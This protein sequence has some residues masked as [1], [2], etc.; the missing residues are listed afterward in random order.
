MSRAAII[1]REE[2]NDRT[3]AAI[4]RILEDRLLSE[5]AQARRG[6]GATKAEAAIHQRIVDK[7]APE[8]LLIQI[9]ITLGLEG[10]PGPHRDSVRGMLDTIVGII[11]NYE[12][13]LHKAVVDEREVTGAVVRELIP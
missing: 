5:A 4:Q 13:D 12:E 3:F 2:L 6:A 8:E 11:G 10:G 1:T 7:T 9:R